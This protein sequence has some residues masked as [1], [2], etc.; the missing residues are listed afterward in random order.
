MRYPMEVKR[1]WNIYLFSYF[2]FL[3]KPTTINLT[4]AK[5]GATRVT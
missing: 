1:N 4:K 5:M 2:N 3:Y